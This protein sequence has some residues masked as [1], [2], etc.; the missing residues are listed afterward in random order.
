MKPGKFLFIIA[1]L[2]LA[3]ALCG[4]P[5]GGGG[6]SG[7]TS[8]RSSGGEAIVPPAPD[9]V[10]IAFVPSTEA[11]KIVEETVEFDKLLGAALGIP[12]KSVV[13]PHY[14]AAVEALGTGDCLVGWIPPL[15]YIYANDRHGARPALI[16]VRKG[17]P[18]YQGQIVVRA[19]SDIEHLEDL[20]GKR[21]AFVD[22]NSTSGNLYPRALLKAQGIDPDTYFKAAIYSGGHDT[23]L[24]AVLQGS[25][26]A[27]A[28]FVD[29]RERVK[30]V[31]PNVMQETRVIAVTDNIPG[32]PVVLAGGKYLSDEWAD[33]IT[34]ALLEVM[35]S[36][37]GKRVIYDIY[38][39]DDLI[40]AT[41]RDF[42]VVRR[43]AK[44]LDM[45][46][47]ASLKTR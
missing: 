30:D 24:F 46:V 17:Q 29:V 19:D 1:P 44:D 32:D 21:F 31:Y 23:A 15:A 42:E 39:I 33:K 36:P 47:A 28:C 38:E 13:L 34:A 7:G 18:Y 41:D 37:E 16:A 12:V 27:C 43:M 6:E 11:E 5:K 10:K 26:D 8:A 40:P 2:C 4:C 3:I 45:D 25:V 20:R 35:H 14:V 9:S 22:P